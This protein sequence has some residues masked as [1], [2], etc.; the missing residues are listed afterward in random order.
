[1]PLCNC[2]WKTGSPLKLPVVEGWGVTAIC[3]GFA[4]HLFILFIFYFYCEWYLSLLPRSYPP[5]PS[6]ESD[7][8]FNSWVD[9]VCRATQIMILLANYCKTLSSLRKWISGH[10]LVGSWHLKGYNSAVLFLSLQI[11]GLSSVHHTKDTYL[12]TAYWWIFVLTSIT[13]PSHRVR[14]WC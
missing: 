14:L 13:R 10:Y 4:F 3:Y 7:N 5:Q 8:L 6:T 9:R 12:C 11:H 2:V 1:M